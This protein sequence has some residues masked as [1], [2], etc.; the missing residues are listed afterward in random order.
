MNEYRK[1]FRKAQREYYWSVP[2]IMIAFFL[3]VILF[4][5]VGWTINIASQPARI[6]S[7]TLDADNVINNYEWFHDANANYVTRSAQV[8]QFKKLLAAETDAVEKTRLRID[9]AAMQSS[10]RDL[11]NK[12]NANSAKA[13]RGIFRG[14]SLPENLNS[15]ACE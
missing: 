9:M 3:A 8:S 10:C 11:A 4:G 2:R 1:D 15:G 13:N 6:V 5:G 14:T 7:K 12:Y